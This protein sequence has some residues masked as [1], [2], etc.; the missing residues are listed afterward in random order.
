MNTSPQLLRTEPTRAVLEQAL[1]IEQGKGIFYYIQVC[2][3]CVFCVRDIQ[4]VAATRT[5]TPAPETP[6]VDAG[7]RQRPTVIRHTATPEQVA[8]G[9]RRRLSADESEA[10]AEEP[11]DYYMKVLAQILM[12]VLVFL[13]LKKW[14]RTNEMW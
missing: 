5:S 12:V 7:M 8:E 2:I 11:L 4:V 10:P 14:A 1:F 3:I 9:R 6:T 13:L